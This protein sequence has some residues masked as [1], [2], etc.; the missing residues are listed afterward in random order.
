VFR[1]LEERFEVANPGTDVVLTFA[2]SQ[3]L[4][5]QIE[6]G[7]PA[8]VFASANPEHVQ[9]LLEAGLVSGPR[10]FATNRLVVVV[11]LDNP[12]GIETFADL[13]RATRLVL[14]TSGV[15]AGRY[16]RAALAA[17]DSVIG[18][19]FS[20][21]VLGK[22]VSEEPNVR[23]ARAKVELGDADAAVV[24]R[25]D[26]LRSD[27]VRVVPLPEGVSV[28]AEY[29]AALVERMDR[30]PLAGRWLDYLLSDTARSVFLRHGFGG[31]EK[32]DG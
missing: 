20:G 19:G 5:I 23:L 30:S 7:A 25:T 9:A 26:A 1:E 22:L 27:R 21:A 3:L 24:Y 16:A 15:P 31:G 14:G 28:R 13:P 8:D 11:P 6:E 29:T 12:A 17:A 10:T 4:R 18:P 32:T 2:G